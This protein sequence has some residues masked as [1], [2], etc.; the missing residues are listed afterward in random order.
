MESI[1]INENKCNYEF[2]IIVNNKANELI[3]KGFI[4]ERI[5]YKKR[6]GTDRYK[7]AIINYISRV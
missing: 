5:K 3:K 4:I 6:N 1:V 2:K 7:S